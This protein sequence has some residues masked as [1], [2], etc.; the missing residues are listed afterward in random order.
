MKDVDFGHLKTAGERDE[1]ERYG[2]IS[3]A[4]SGLG[5]I[6]DLRDCRDVRVYGA[7]GG[8][9]LNASRQGPDRGPPACDAVADA[10]G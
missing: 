8:L 5:V 7:G 1:G 2:A 6:R 9:N 4:T 3:L 10:E